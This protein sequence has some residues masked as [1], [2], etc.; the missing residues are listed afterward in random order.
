MITH[1][2]VWD[3]FNPRYY[4]LT[5]KMQAEVYYLISNLVNE[6]ILSLEMERAH[7]PVD[8]ELSPPAKDSTEHQI[9][10]G[11]GAYLLKTLGETNVKF[12]YK[13]CDVYGLDLKIRIECGQTL[14][15]RLFESLIKHEKDSEFWVLQSYTISSL[16]NYD[17]FKFKYNPNKY[18]DLL[19]IFNNHTK[20]KIKYKERHVKYPEY[21]EPVFGVIEHPF[22][23]P[24]EVILESLERFQ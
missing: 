10:K 20:N 9:L 2:D 18:K 23:D 19:D 21:W 11:I 3:I 8:L 5:E 13:Y 1:K 16:G 15:D 17:L 6:G 4:Y 12:E 7:R 22:K 14:G 24:E